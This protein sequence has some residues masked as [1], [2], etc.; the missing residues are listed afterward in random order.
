MLPADGLTANT[1]PIRIL[2]IGEEII[3]GEFNLQGHSCQKLRQV[4]QVRGGGSERGH[5]CDGAMSCHSVTVQ[6]HVPHLDII[7]STAASPLPSLLSPPPA[8]ARQTRL[9]SLLAG[10]CDFR[11]RLREFKR[12][13]AAPNRAGRAA[14]NGVNGSF[15]LSRSSSNAE[16]LMDVFSLLGGLHGSRSLFSSPSPLLTRRQRLKQKL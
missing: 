13:E 14:G 8:N 9:P 4:P 15:I 2:I 7:G 6:F 12:G 11:G 16:C 5:R 1:L 10:I 3:L